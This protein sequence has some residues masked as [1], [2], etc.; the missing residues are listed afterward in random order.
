VRTRCDYSSR[1]SLSSGCTFLFPLIV[2]LLLLMDFK[3]ACANFEGEIPLRGRGCD[4]PGFR[5][6]CHSRVLRVPARVRFGFCVFVWER[7]SDRRLEWGSDP[8]GLRT[9]VGGRRMRLGGPVGGSG[10]VQPGSGCLS[11]DAT[12]LTDAFL[13]ATTLGVASFIGPLACRLAPTVP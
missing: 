9:V 3:F 10:N 5:D 1:T 12:A 8:C 6:R 11:R 7:A 4:D 13:N 2:I